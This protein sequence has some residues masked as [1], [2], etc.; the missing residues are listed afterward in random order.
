MR[1]P[2]QSCLALLAAILLGGC[3][4]GPNFKRP[5]ANVPATFK[6]HG[7]DGDRSLAELDWTGVYQDSRLQELIR[8]ALS[9]GYD[10]RIA[11]A[12]VS[13]YRAMAAEVHGMLLPSV[14]YAANAD[15]GRN[16]LLGNAY[17]Q[18]GGSTADGFDGYLRRRVGSWTCGRRVRR[19]DEAARAQYHLES[20]AARRAVL[21]S[22]VSDVATA[23]YEL[24]QLDEE[25]A[26]AVQTAA[27]FADSLRLFER[28]LEED[29]LPPRYRQCRGRHGN[30]RGAN[31]R[32][33]DADCGE[34][35]PAER[36][37][38]K[39]AGAGGPRSRPFG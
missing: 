35:K 30:E 8:A 18:G 29:R 14:G 23:Y 39:P 31:S 1:L 13:E 27:S 37:G 3:A 12:R 36:P 11:A 33:R 32:H 2:T 17:T 28:Q 21:L 38:R 26:I 10:A 4:I 20:E 24:L 19:L 25:R 9:N 34:G 22:L 16:A 6:D 5:D 15:R 7:N